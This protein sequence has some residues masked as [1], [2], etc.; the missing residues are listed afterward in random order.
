VSERSR[1]FSEAGE[2]KAA[3]QRRRKEPETEQIVPSDY[4]ATE[5]I[6]PLSELPYQTRRRPH[7][8]QEY[9]REEGEE[10]GDAKRGTRPLIR[11][12][13]YLYADDRLK[14]ELSQHIDLPP[15]RRS[16]RNEATPQDE[17]EL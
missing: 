4:P 9:L 15:V 6:V 2:E 12:A 16:S 3:R 8:E 13:P 17:E 1:G 11:R 10:D 7:I 14:Q 5:E